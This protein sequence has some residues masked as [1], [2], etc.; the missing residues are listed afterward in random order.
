MSTAPV[1][2]AR[3]ARIREIATARWTATPQRGDWWFNTHHQNYQAVLRAG[4]F[5]VVDAHLVE[6]TDAQFER[7]LSR[8]QE[9]RGNAQRALAAEAMPSE[10]AA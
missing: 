3:E 2:R 9:I 4:P 6:M 7:W 10:E 1:A 5:C 8:V